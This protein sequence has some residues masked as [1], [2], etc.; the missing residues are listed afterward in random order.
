MASL[1]T[2][3]PGGQLI[4]QL[5]GLAQ[6]EGLQA[7]ALRLKDL[8]LWI[9]NDLNDFE[10]E[11]NVLQRS[12]R[13]V[14]Q[15]AHHLL[16]LGGKHLRPMCV[17]LANKMGP[18]PRLERAKLC[19]TSVEWVHA[20][21]LLHDDVVDMGDKRRG[22]KCAR[23]V[24]G[25]AA[26]IFAGDWLLIKA[27]QSIRTVGVA[28]LLDKMLLIIDEM[29]VAESVQL[30]N[31]GRIN[32]SMADYF[33]VVEGKTAALFRWAMY[34]GSTV[35]ACNDEEVSAM[36]DFGLHLG[37][38][39]QLIDDLL[40]VDGDV[41]HTGKE[42]FADLREGKMTYPILFAVNEKP[43][44]TEKIALCAGSQDSDGD[45]TPIYKDIIGHLSE[46]GALNACRAL[47]KEHADL[48]I[49]KLDIFKD[50]PGKDALRTVAEASI[51]RHL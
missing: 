18:T 17:L 32:S 48:A 2:E 19:A 26:S 30:E 49:S 24:Y 39:F 38:A 8:H 4:E 46:T 12:E 42:L 45:L 51:K 28:A 40:D 3:N 43:E 35:G 41:S 13:I 31:R 33:H 34:A 25:N 37:V 10:N 21:T 20:A 44:L 5:S 23:L 9:A 22:G 11:L 27:L 36:E 6:K 15:S 29:I 50:G 16:D 1:I 47:A 14:L 7:L